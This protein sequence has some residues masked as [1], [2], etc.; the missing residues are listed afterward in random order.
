MR[1]SYMGMRQKSATACMALGDVGRGR[2]SDAA[3][4]GDNT[5]SSSQ[6]FYVSLVSAGFLL[7]FSQSV[8]RA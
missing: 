5:A 8:P 6:R 7:V 2:E 4:F 1:A 3:V